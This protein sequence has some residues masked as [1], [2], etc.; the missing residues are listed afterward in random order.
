M[1]LGKKRL[2][3]DIS[4]MPVM[5]GRL[6]SSGESEKDVESLAL[7]GPQNAHSTSRAGVSAARTCT[8]ATLCVV[9]PP[10]SQRRGARAWCACSVRASNGHASTCRLGSTLRAMMGQ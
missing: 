1:S 10:P 8:Y 7:D 2:I 9:G 3:P 5:D 6:F 4:E